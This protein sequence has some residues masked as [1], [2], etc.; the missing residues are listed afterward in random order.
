MIIDTHAHYD[1]EAF[2]EDREELLSS[3]KENGIERVINVAANM[4]GARA[5]VE[6]AHRYPFIFA[7]VGVH[8]DDCDEI[9]EETLAELEELCKDEKV[10]AIGE[11]GLD[12]Y[13]DNVDRE[14]QKKTFRQQLA[15][16]KKVN[17]PVI[18]HSRDAAKDTVDIL[19]EE[20]SKGIKGVM[21]CYSYSKETAEILNK[22]DFYYGIGGVV[23]FKNAKKLVEALEVI[24][25]DRI[26]LETDCPYLAPTPFRGKRN[27]SL[28]ISYVVEKL[29]EIK[30][31]T[32]EEVE[33]ITSENAK[34]VF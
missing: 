34:R 2:D 24:P 1:D 21:H 5:S 32:K 4:K 25:M 29:A 33:R 11:I 18:I 8:P 17:L 6:L 31:I 23:T 16:A 10:V 22:L 30:G 27:C 26:L 3:L 13:W 15:L 19:M 7:A 20:E 28:Y 12:Y 9:N 14:I